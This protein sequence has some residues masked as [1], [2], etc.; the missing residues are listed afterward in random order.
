MKFAN[1]FGKP[2]KGLHR[3]RLCDVALVDYALTIVA[4]IITSCSTGFPLVLSTIVWL[5]IGLVLHVLFGV[6]T[7]AV[8][9]LGL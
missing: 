7:S 1:I 2:G 9:W 8:K 4:A 6:H 5:I 3:F